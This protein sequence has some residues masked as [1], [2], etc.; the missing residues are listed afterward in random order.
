M[1]IPPTTAQQARGP[2]GGYGVGDVTGD[3][4]ARQMGLQARGNGFE[5]GMKI[6]LM[7][8]ALGLF[9][10]THAELPPFVYDEM[11][12]DAEEVVVVQILKAPKADAK[13]IGKRQQL[14][15]EAKVLRI[16]RSKSRLRPS[17]TITIQSSYYR[18]GSGEVGPSNPRRLKKNDV[19]T[20]YLNKSKKAGEFQIAAGGHSFEKPP[21]EVGEKKTD[22][23]K[24][25]TKEGSTNVIESGL[26]KDGATCLFIGHS[27]FIPVAKSFGQ[28]AKL[29]GFSKHKQLT[30]F[31]GGQ[32]GTPGSLWKSKRHSER[33]KT[34]LKSGK[35]Q[36][37]GMTVGFNSSFD[38]Y[39]RW[40][41]FALEHNPKTKFM[42]GL[43]WGKGG[44]SR[45]AKEFTEANLEAFQTLFE[46]VTKLRKAFPKNSITLINY[47]AAACELKVQFEA[48]KLKGD[49]SKMVDRKSGL[50]TDN[51]LGHAGPMIIDLSALIWLKNLYGA[52]FDKLKLTRKY[53]TDLKVTAAKIAKLNDRFVKK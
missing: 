4:P 1:G 7:S 27:F 47:G 31:S 49:I 21:A 14:I 23:E 2:A 38:D 10:T 37:L 40:I 8:L 15:Y 11:K 5:W 45:K 44:Q 34:I 35:I 30:V 52:D 48:G 51:N 13:L 50:F 18:F 32:S 41:D 24:P 26:P 16:T 22:V 20:A 25:L 36:L 33:I 46:M 29:N 19:V 6:L 3:L 43:C 17:A 53:K 42:V 12:R 28:H 9:F 39:K